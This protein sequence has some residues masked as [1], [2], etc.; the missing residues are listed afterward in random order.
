MAKITETLVLNAADAVTYAETRKT[1]ETARKPSVELIER[2]NAVNGRADRFT[3]SATEVIEIALDTEL[4]LK[5]SGV[6][7][8]HR[9]GAEVM[10]RGAGPSAASYK[11]S[12]K[13]TSVRLRRKAGGWY[14]VS[15]AS[16]TVYAK[17][18]ERRVLAIKPAQVEKVIAAA[19]APFAVF[20]PA[21]VAQAA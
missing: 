11:G 2:V 6:A 13:A 12:C 14:L 9:V 1:P 19:M 21:P 4:R 7:K 3:T 18:A 5:R 16:D 10:H 17:T 15:V 8:S 20:E